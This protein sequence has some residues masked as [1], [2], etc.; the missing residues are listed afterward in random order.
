VIFGTGGISAASGHSVGLALMELDSPGSIQRLET[1]TSEG[2]EHNI[3]LKSSFYA[4]YLLNWRLGTFSPN[5]QSGA[6]VII[7][8]FLA[9]MAHM[10]DVDLLHIRS[11]EQQILLNAVQSM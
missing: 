6:S 11:I 1:R 8:S 9:G 3:H 2:D 7:L 4:L 10:S 5:W